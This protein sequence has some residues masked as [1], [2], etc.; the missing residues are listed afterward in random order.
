VGY[1]R[2]FNRQEKVEEVKK[3]REIRSLP[4]EGIATQPTASP[5]ERH[6]NT[7]YAAKWTLNR[8]QFQ[9]NKNTVACERVH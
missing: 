2:F 4:K 8:W 3:W 7:K 5:Y 6:A 1:V 9:K